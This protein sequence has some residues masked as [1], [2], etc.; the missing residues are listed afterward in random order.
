[1]RSSTRP[2]AGT[3]AEGAI[4]A[5]DEAVP[6]G[7]SRRTFLASG[8]AVGV[9]VGLGPL[10]TG[11]VAL[12]AGGGS[13]LTE[14]DAAILRFLAAAEILEAD[15][16]QQYNELGGI[17]DSQVPGGSGSK[18][19]VEA[20]EVLDEDMPQYIHDNTQDEFSHAAFINAYLESRH[21]EPVNLDQFRTLPSSTASGA[22]QIGR[23]TN[24][25]ELT[26]D[27][28]WWTRYR[29]SHE[30]PGSRRHVRA[31]G[32]GAGRR[33]VPGDSSERRRPRAEKAHPGNREHG[34][35][36]LWHDRA[37]RDEPLPG[38]RSEGDRSGGAAHPAQHRP[39]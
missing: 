27:T 34:R 18:P 30:E 35:V 17:Q 28:T 16:W 21:A 33:E 4:A 15:L 8:L 24:L 6:G 23:L 22:Q 5:A 11:A 37:G 29:S 13:G 9:G 39:D 2:P 1:M 32:A 26:V 3:D 19:Y 10:G 12:A 38:A 20:L 25:M 7:L 14:G 31:G 36:P